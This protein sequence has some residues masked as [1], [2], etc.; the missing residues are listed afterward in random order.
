MKRY[1]HNVLA[2]FYNHH[3]SKGKMHCPTIPSANDIQ[4]AMTEN[5]DRQTNEVELLEALKLALPLL[6]RLGDFIGNKENRC[7]AVLA[8]N[9]VLRKLTPFDP[10][11][12]KGY[13]PADNKAIAKVEEK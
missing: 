3:Y 2:D 11:E 5:Y 1:T 6:V 9:T 7:E 4:K 13:V 8:A 10:E 12:D